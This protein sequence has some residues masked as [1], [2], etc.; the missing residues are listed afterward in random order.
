MK[1]ASWRRYTGPQLAPELLLSGALFL[2]VVQIPHSSSRAAQL[3]F[4][5]AGQ[6]DD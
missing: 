5:F 4:P 2:G 1:V 6:W 3:L